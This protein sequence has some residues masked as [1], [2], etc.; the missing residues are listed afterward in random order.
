M[1]NVVGSDI[2]AHILSLS[3]MSR[4]W[5]QLG[6]PVINQFLPLRIDASVVIYSISELEKRK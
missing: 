3:P 5:S 2:K 6:P 1:I 4:F